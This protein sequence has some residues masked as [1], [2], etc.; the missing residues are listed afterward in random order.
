MWTFWL[1]AHPRSRGEN[2]SD[3]GARLSPPR[4]IPA[5]AG[6]TSWTSLATPPTTAHPRSRGE[7]GRAQVGSQPVGG[8]SPLTRGK[9]HRVERR[10]GGPPAHPRSR[11]ENSYPPG[12]S[13]VRGGSSPLTR[14]KRQRRGHGTAP[15]LAHPRSRGENSLPV[16]INDTSTGSSPLTRGK[17]F[18]DPEGTRDARLI[19]AH[20]GKT[21]LWPS[22]GSAR[23]AHPRSRGENMGEIVGVRVRGGSS[24]LTRGKLPARRRLEG[25]CRLIPA[26][27]GKTRSTLCAHKSRRAHPRSRG[28]NACVSVS[29][30]CSCGSSPLT[31]GKPPHR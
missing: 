27:A 19:P 20:A 10:G 5:H 1:E 21:S 30:F 4:L 28:E 12:Q 26:H 14:G 16:K 31:R 13:R 25:H 9:P 3:C 6:K 18:L 17:R 24:P 2:V 11:G 15:P 29:Y 22:I 8:S 23:R 7:N